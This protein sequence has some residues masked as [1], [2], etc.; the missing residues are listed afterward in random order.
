MILIGYGYGYS[1]IRITLRSQAIAGWDRKYLVLHWAGPAT[2][3]DF[4]K[5]PEFGILM[6]FGTFSMQIQMGRKIVNLMVRGPF[7][8]TFGKC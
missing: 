8:D 6:V 3:R 4:P 5:T 2:L 7:L 1:Q